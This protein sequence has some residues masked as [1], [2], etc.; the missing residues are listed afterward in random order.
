M[1]QTQRT[2]RLL[3]ADKSLLFCRGLR[4]F[5]NGEKD[6]EVID[7][8]S[9]MNE[10]LAKARILAPDV[11]IINVELLRSEE[12]AF[13]FALRQA[14]A[15]GSILALTEDDGEEC[16]SCAVAAGAKGYM[17]KNS[18]PAQ[19]AEGVRQIALSESCHSLSI[20]KIV[21]DLK[22][23]AEQNETK[24]QTPV[25]TARESEVMRLLAEGKTVR[26]AA[27]ELS[28][29]A[30]TVEAHKLN[31]MRKLDIHHRAALV[32]YAVQ[33]GLVPASSIP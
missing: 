5:L 7:I 11:L 24:A 17:L 10:T 33:H 2:S 3:I 27:D 32:A 13:R 12:P 29:S 22:A 15:N 26:E 9:A 19:L 20:S 23:L 30:K 14:M 1:K 16:L 18:T 25:L 21:P 8:A 4:T 31:L 28:L 6:L